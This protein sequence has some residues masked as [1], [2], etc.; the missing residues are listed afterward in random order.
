MISRVVTI[1]GPPGSGKS[2]ASRTVADALQLT[3]H[4]AGEL[5]R[6][7]AHRRGMDLETFGHYAEGHPEVDEALDRAMQAL[8]TPGSLLDGRVQGALCRQRGVPV[9]EIRITA[10]DEERIRRV[11]QRDGQ[12]MVDAMRQVK[13]REASERTRYARFYGID[14]DRAVP[15]LAIDTTTRSP[16]NVATEIIDFLRSRER[17][18]AP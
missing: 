5:F 17:I 7:E 1:G 3:Y 18:G 16:D 9:Y 4:A 13:E 8:A 10:S 12:S 6:A 15:D 11:A 14:L 2:T